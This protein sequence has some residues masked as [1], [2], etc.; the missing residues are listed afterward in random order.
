MKPELAARQAEL[1]RALGLDTTE[2]RAAAIERAIRLYDRIFALA[3][4]I[5]ANHPGVVD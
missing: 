5:V 3:D 2:A 1:L 4:E